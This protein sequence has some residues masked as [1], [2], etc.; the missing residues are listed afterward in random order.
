MNKRKKK[1]QLKKHI[2]KL[3]ENWSSNEFCKILAGQAINKEVVDSGIRAERP[4][5]PNFFELEKK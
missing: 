5:P 4:T 3:T 2:Q 1:K